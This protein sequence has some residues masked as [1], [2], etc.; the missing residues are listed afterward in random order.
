MERDCMKEGIDFCNCKKVELRSVGRNHQEADFILMKGFVTRRAVK[1]CSEWLCELAE[2][3]PSPRGLSGGW[4]EVPDLAGEV[5]SLAGV[6]S[7]PAISSGQMTGFK[8][9][10]STLKFAGFW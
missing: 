8:E 7:H 5:T 10:N 3:R 4:G 2:L 9:D 1:S 6:L